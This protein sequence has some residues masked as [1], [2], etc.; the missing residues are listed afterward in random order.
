LRGSVHGGKIASE[1]SDAMA[2]FGFDAMMQLKRP[3]LAAMA[4]M[5]GRLYEGIAAV[6]KEW[7]TFVNRC[8]KEDLAVPQ[9]LAQC[10]TTQDLYQVY[11]QF[12]QNTW[13]QYRSGLEQMTKLGRAIAEHA[14][15]S[16]SGDS[17]PTQH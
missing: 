4:E 10:R 14:L 6:N 13:A 11:A 12:F 8:L 3:A 16:R 17:G 7:A 2:P 15:E 5:N 1:A 9:Q